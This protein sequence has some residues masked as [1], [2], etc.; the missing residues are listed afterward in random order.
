MKTLTTSKEKI[1]LFDSCDNEYMSLYPEEVIEKASS[2]ISYFLIPEAEQEDEI[3]EINE[4][5]KALTIMFDEQKCI[6]E[7]LAEALDIL[8]VVNIYEC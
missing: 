7:R 6:D 5:K 2:Y 8:E 4:Y 1:Q 3:E